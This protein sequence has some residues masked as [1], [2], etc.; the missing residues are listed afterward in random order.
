MATVRAALLNQDT[1]LLPPTVPLRLLK[2][3]VPNLLPGAFSQIDKAAGLTTGLGLMTNATKAV[4]EQLGLKGLLTKTAKYLRPAVVSAKPVGVKAALV[5]PLRAL[6][7]LLV[8][9]ERGPYH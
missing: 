7:R 4:S 3:K 6:P 2:L 8:V 5:W 9:S 1:V